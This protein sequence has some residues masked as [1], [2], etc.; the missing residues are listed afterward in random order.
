MNYKVWARDMKAKLVIK[1][2]MKHIEN[3]LKEDIEEKMKD[4]K[5]SVKYIKFFAQKVELKLLKKEE[6]VNDPNITIENQRRE[7]EHTIATNERSLAAK[8]IKKVPLKKLWR[9]ELKQLN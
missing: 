6:D 3:E 9:E 8:S 5:N 7:R 1:K 2:F 4:L